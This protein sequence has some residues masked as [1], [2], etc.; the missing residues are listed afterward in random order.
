MDSITTKFANNLW[1]SNAVWLVSRQ[2]TEVAGPWNEALSLDDERRI[3]LPCRRGSSLV[4]FVPECRRVTCTGGGAS[5]PSRMPERRGMLISADFTETVDR[6]SS[7]AGRQPKN[8]G[9]QR[10]LIF[11]SGYF[12]FI[13]RI[14]TC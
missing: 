10:C 1:M 9:M 2:L 8:P 14:K 6:L 4:K 3:L 13:R 11:K 12:T 7:V 5:E